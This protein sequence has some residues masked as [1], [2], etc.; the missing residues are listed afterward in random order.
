MQLN[1]DDRTVMTTKS[2]HDDDDDEYENR[3]IGQYLAGVWLNER[4]EMNGK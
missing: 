3:L 4:G 2:V 1:V